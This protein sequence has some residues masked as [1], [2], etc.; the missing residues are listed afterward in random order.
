[1]NVDIWQRYCYHGDPLKN[2]TTAVQSREDTGY[3]DQ[4][5]VDTQS[6]RIRDCQGIFDP[7]RTYETILSNARQL[8]RKKGYHYVLNIK[9]PENPHL[10]LVRETQKLSSHHRTLHAF[11]PQK[12]RKNGK[13][14]ANHGGFGF[15]NYRSEQ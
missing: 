15:L 4:R 1:M 6:L 5:M 2:S 7:E 10:E 14:K 13:K 3:L 8:P 12:E 9:N 11:Q